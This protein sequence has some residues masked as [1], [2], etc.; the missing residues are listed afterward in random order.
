MRRY[1]NSSKLQFWK[2]F[3]ES[4]MRCK[5]KYERLKDNRLH[6]KNKM[7]L[8]NMIVLLNR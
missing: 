2:F 1:S 5:A 3:F 8:V 7:L 6:K 4:K